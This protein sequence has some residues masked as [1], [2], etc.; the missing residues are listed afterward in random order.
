MRKDR[1]LVGK[2]EKSVKSGGPKDQGVIEVRK[3]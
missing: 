3:T 2:S 1:V